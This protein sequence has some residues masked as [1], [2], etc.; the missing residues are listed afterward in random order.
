MLIEWAAI[1]AAVTPHIQKYAAERAEKLAGKYADGIFAKTYR[2]IVPDQ[3]LV[4]ANQ[5]FVTRFDD[6]LDTA[7]DMP[8]LNAKPYEDALKLFLANPYVQD[9][10]QAP[11]D[12]ESKL[13]GELLRGIWSETRD[14]GGQQL[15]EPPADFDWTRVAKKYQKSIQRQMLYDPELRPVIH[16]IAGLR[17]AEANERTAAAAE[18]LAGPARTFDLARY[19]KDLKAALSY[20]KLGSLDPDWTHYEH[21]V[22]L[23]TI[24]VPQSVKEALPPRDLTRDYLRLLKEENRASAIEAQDEQLQRLKNEYSEL[25][26]RPLMQV[27]DDPAHQRLVMLGD[28]GLGKSTLLKHL[29]LRWAENPVSPF[30]I[31]IELRR[32]ARYESFLEYLEKA[33]DQTCCLPGIELDKYLKEHQALVLLDGLDEVPEGPRTDIVSKI[34]SFS[35]DYP[36]ARIVVTTRIHGY[37]PG[38]Q[39]PERFRDAGFRQFTLQDFDKAEIDRFIQLWHKEAFSNSAE[40]A[41]Y[42]SRLRSALNDSPAISELAANPLLL[43]MMAILSR[44][45]DLPRDR[46]KLYERCAELLLK[47]WDLEKFPELKEKRDA[48][49]IKDKLGPDQ[50]M[51]I[52]EQVAAAMQA[53]RT[54]LA[55][56][57]I[58]EDKLRQIVNRELTVLAVPQSWVVADDLIWM[59]RERN[60]ML[61]YLGDR[62][63]AF[64]HRTFLEYFCARDLKYRLERTSTFNLTD[65][66][67]LFQEHWPQDAWHE[68]L[69]LLCGLI[70]VEYAAACVSE[71]SSFEQQPGGHEAVLLAA[72]CLREIREVRSIG[73][74]RDEAR[75]ALSRL[76]SF[77]PPYFYDF[78]SPEVREVEH[79]RTT[80]VQELAR[81]WRDDPDTLPWLKERAARDQNEYVRQAAVQEL[82]RGWKDDPDTLPWLKERAARDQNSSVR[83]AAVQE[84]A[85]GWKDN[86]GTLPWLK[87]LAARDQNED[88]C[89]AAVQELARGWKDDP[90]TLPWLKERAARDQNASVRQAA[91]Q[92]LARGWKD[93]PGTLPWLKELAARD[94]NEDVRSAAVQELA[95]GWKDDPDTLP[96]L[97]ERAARD[98]NED[99]RSAAVEALARGWKDDPDTLP[100]LKERAARDQNEYVRMTAVQELARGWKDDPDTLPMLKERA[101][102]DQN[103]YVRITA[104]QELARGWR[105]DPDTLPWLKERAARDQNEYVR[106]TAVQ[107][108]ARGWK[109]DPDTLPMLKERA[110]RDQNEYVRM[111]AVQELARGWKDDPDTLPML[112]ERAA[113]DQNEDVRSAAVQELARGWKDDPDTLPMLKERAARDENEDVRSAAVQA[114]ARGWKDDPD[115]LPWLKERAARDQ[116]E[117][118]RS[119]AVQELARGWKD[120]PDTLPWLKERAA[121]DQNEDVR[122]AAVQELARGWKDD[123]DTLPWLKE[124]AARDQNASVRITAVQELA[125]GWKDDPDTLPWLKERAARDQNASVRRTAVQALARGWKDDPD[126]LPMLKELAARDQ[127]ASVRMTAVQALARGW[128]DDPDTL[129]MLKELAARD[130]DAS[131]RMTAVQELARGWKDDPDTL[132]MLKELAARDQDASVRMTAVQA[133]A[134]GWKDDPD[135]L[136]MLKERAARDQNEDVRSAAVQALARGWK[137]DP[138]TLPML[139]ERAARDQH[140]AVRRTAVQE[141]ARGWKDDPAVQ[142]F[143]AN[144]G[145]M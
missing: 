36:S 106:I 82:A 69:R 85:R 117:D 134:R 57:L 10:I 56:N 87:E 20:L 123:P 78:W 137:D 73:K 13:D 33:A 40:R 27:V 6:E 138:D 53:E 132:P 100:M 112:K 143:L 89:S 90:D 127:D 64:V 15:M 38:S 18:R 28:P 86:P 43:T 41:R 63:Y 61:G 54:G 105:D 131:V 109:D 92:E 74:E 24:Y 52:L 16:A 130:Q 114:L 71:L 101:A 19:A 67:E 50:K 84:L 133:L 103:E 77:D 124:R 14:E 119:A 111:T 29:A 113:R 116:N 91:V 60:F 104:V 30:T 144:E 94:E 135:T 76:I 2:R 107:A 5:A 32:A 7:M 122:S 70:G 49:D 110:A 68:V 45:Q 96:M 35:N 66:R 58:S 140:A 44:N 80:A 108:L 31:L 79:V 99:V 83:Q 120:D 11:L 39:H 55:G 88:V 102:R 42:E 93:N 62:Q 139:K 17:D 128:K 129:P 97:K 121:R 115:T 9:A 136:P 1:S 98:E 22:R 59:L 47:N 142:H 26:A 125:R 34:I 126:T 37:H 51:R 75:R 145:L 72:Q 48:R 46:G 3:K 95:R 65:L 4:K 25:R 141:L 81:G 8:T 12:G 118:V 23:E 21:R